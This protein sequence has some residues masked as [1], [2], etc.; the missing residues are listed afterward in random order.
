MSSCSICGAD[1]ENCTFKEGCGGCAATNGRPFGEECII[2][3]CY[4][5]CEH[6]GK[7]TDMACKLKE[8]LIGE[9]NSLGIEDMETVTELFALKGSFVNLEYTVPCGQTIKLLNDNR[10]YLGNQ[11][12]KKDSDRCYGLAAD[13][14]IL[15]VC[16][17]GENGANA[18]IVVYKRRKIQKLS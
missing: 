11:L 1:C 10:I 18:Q 2:A 5:N 9:F 16:E 17:Y 4:E 6:R 3:T 12:T 8:Q 7:C 15:L 13:K 14:N